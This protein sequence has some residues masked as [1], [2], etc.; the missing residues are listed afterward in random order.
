M[1]VGTV[2]TIPGSETVGIT[3][4][5]APKGETGDALMLRQAVSWMH[6]NE[7]DLFVCF[8]LRCAVCAV[9]IIVD[10]TQ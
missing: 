3:H 10:R 8:F 4:I 6:T 2:S 1:V 5:P 9:V 7:P